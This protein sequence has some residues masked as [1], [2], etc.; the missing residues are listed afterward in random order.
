MNQIQGPNLYT[1][2]PN[3]KLAIAGID[4]KKKP[5]TDRINP[6]HKLDT[7]RKD[8]IDTLYKDGQ[9]AFSIPD[10]GGEDQLSTPDT[11]GENQ[12]HILEAGR[13]R[14]VMKPG[15]LPTSLSC[16]GALRA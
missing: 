15:G 13:M 7:Y 11:D 4:Q 9:D 3:A 2:D 6:M 16:I 1:V 14:L 5:G 8:Q 10:A 12:N